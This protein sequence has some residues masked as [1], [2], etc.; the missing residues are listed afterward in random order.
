[1]ITTVRAIHRNVKHRSSGDSACG[2]PPRAC[3]KP[4]PGSGTPGQRGLANLAVKI[5]VDPLR[6]RQTATHS[7]LRQHAH[8]VTIGAGRDA[9]SANS[10]INA[11]RTS[12]ESPSPTLTDCSI[13]D[14]AA[15]SP[16]L[17]KQLLS[18]RRSHGPRKRAGCRFPCP[19]ALWLRTAEPH[20]G[21]LEQHCHG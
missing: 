6:P 16:V 19:A 7:G 14:G 17:A 4:R 5:E 8:V 9:E 10:T 20:D 1:M 12:S 3:S 21:A 18:D 15:T 11:P 13:H 2:G